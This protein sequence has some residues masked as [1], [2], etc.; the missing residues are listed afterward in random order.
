MNYDFHS[1]ADFTVIA[2][3]KG[4]E[5]LGRVRLSSRHRLFSELARDTHTP[6]ELPSPNSPLLAL[7]LLRLGSVGVLTSVPVALFSY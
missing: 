7:P 6:R 4:E 1:A 2:S 3:P 5:G